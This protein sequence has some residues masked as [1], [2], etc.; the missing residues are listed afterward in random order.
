MTFGGSTGFTTGGGVV[1]GASAD[2]EVGVDV[3]VCSGDGDVVS[4]DVVV[5]DAVSVDVVGAVHGVSAVCANAFAPIMSAE[6]PSPAKNER[7]ADGVFRL[8][9]VERMKNNRAVLRDP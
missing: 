4:V 9:I 8:R 6:T 2:V 7:T 5:A 3:V 1:G